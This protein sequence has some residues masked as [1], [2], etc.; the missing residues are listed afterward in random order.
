MSLLSTLFSILPVVL[1][2]KFLT[3]LVTGSVVMVV[4]PKAFAF[5]KSKLTKAE[6]VVPSVVQTAEA[7]VANTVSTAVS[8]AEKKV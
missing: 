2:G 4:S 5:V 7:E 1:D 8:S 6:A 3:G